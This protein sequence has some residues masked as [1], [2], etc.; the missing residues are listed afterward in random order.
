[1]V[2][3]IVLRRASAF[4]V[5]TDC[6][7]E[8]QQQQWRGAQVQRCKYRVRIF[9]SSSLSAT[10]M[11]VFHHWLRDARAVR[12]LFTQTRDV[13]VRGTGGACELGLTCETTSTHDQ[14][15]STTSDTKMKTRP[16][17]VNHGSGYVCDYEPWLR[18]RM[19]LLCYAH[20]DL[21]L[22]HI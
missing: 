22:I 21:S 6:S 5:A 4:S 10:V 11:F 13:V 2:F 18:I 19:R 20:Q 16:V 15:L 14:K 8:E 9:S 17:H 7:D 12:R 3:R 1:M